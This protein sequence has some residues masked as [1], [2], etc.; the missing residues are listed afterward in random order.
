MQFQR[1]CDVFRKPIK[2][3][4]FRGEAVP[5]GKRLIEDMPLTLQQDVTYEEGK[6]VLEKVFFLSLIAFIN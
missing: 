6:D 4:S 2:N 3:F 1:F 5:G